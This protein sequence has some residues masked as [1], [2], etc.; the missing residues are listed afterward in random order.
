MR[1]VRLEGLKRDLRNVNDDP[2]VP[3]EVKAKAAALIKKIEIQR[4][5]RK[6]KTNEGAEG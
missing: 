1:G 4:G 3:W 2:D 6:P 5:H